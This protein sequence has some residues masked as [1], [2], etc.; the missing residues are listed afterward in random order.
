M[1]KKANEDCQKHCNEIQRKYKEKE[2]DN[3]KKQL[4]EE[5]KYEETQNK[6]NK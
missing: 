3:L 5:K 1:Q 6:R 2:E 4:E